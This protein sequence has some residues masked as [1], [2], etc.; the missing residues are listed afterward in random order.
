MPPARRARSVLVAVAVALAPPLFGGLTGSTAGCARQ[1]PDALPGVRLGMTPRD[2]R[3]RFDPGGPGT[4]QTKVGAGD[5]T[6]LEW[7]AQGSG[8]RVA[9]AR[10]EFHLGMLVA[11]RA[12]LAEPSSADK[13]ELTPRTVTARRPAEEGGTEVTVLARDCPTHR[14][15]AE[16]LAGRAR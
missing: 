11:I 14:E 12:R 15:E 16:S 8:A 4:W 5:D 9:Q 6:V 3:E 10:F 1:E 2:V 13:V 7:A